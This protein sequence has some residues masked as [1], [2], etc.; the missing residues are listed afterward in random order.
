[1]IKLSDY[2]WICFGNAREREF[3]TGKSHFMRW[4]SLGE[5]L[6]TNGLMVYHDDAGGI[7]CIKYV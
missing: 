3:F 4:I 2:W 5:S 6:S 7:G 1:M